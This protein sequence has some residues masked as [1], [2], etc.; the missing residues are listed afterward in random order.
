MYSF[1]EQHTTNWPLFLQ[2]L[3][4]RLLAA[5][6]VSFNIGCSNIHVKSKVETPAKSVLQAEPTKVAG[7]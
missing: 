3:K 4:I 5:R 6:L 1:K 7:L 2:K